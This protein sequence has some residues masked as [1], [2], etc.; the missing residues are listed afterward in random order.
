MEVTRAYL[1]LAD[2]EVY[3]PNN[4]S[5]DHVPQVA[6]RVRSRE[7]QTNRG[8]RN[9]GGAGGRGAAVNIPEAAEAVGKATLTD[10]GLAEGRNRN[11]TRGNNDD[12]NA[13]II[14]TNIFADPT[15]MIQV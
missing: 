4:V 8:H 5:P 12:I 15:V 14:D 11:F 9:A 3:V 13:N 7:R 6:H 10:S 2:G 1:E